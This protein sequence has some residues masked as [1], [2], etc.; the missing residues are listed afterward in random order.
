[1]FSYLTTGSHGKTTFI[2]AL[3]SLDSPVCMKIKQKIIT[4][5]QETDLILILAFIKEKHIDIK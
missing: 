1:M 2:S 5:I 4:F 3:V